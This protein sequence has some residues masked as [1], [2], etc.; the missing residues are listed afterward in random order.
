MTSRI[1]NSRKRALLLAAMIV[2]LLF[3]SVFML[4]EIPSSRSAARNSPPTMPVVNSDAELTLPTI[5]DKTEQTAT[6]ESALIAPQRLDFRDYNLIDS[7][8]T[9]TETG[10]LIANTGPAPFAFIDLKRVFAA[11]ESEMSSAETKSNLLSK[12]RLAA[13]SKA[14]S[15]GITFLFDAS[16]QGLKGAP[17]FFTNGILDIT[18]ELLIELSRLTNN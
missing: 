12:V 5:A 18:D 6:N 16:A 9:P 4:R 11:H 13:A 2:L 7:G 1:K 3:L 10:G 8:T 15:H 17:I 14:R